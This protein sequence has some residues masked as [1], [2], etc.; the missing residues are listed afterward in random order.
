[1][2]WR[3][4]RAAQSS[5]SYRA[6]VVGIHHGDRSCMESL[7]PPSFPI[8]IRRRRSRRIPEHFPEL[9][10]LVPAEGTWTRPRHPVHGHAA[11][12]SSH[13]AFGDRTDRELWMARQLL[14]IW[15][16]WSFLGRRVVAMVPR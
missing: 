11:G 15:I 13:T 5:H 16:V 14:D 12:R 1:M 6:V 2:A 7:V 9:L 8:S 4:G 3:Y 10:R